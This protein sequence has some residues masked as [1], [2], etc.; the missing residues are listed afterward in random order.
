MYVGLYCTWDFPW[1]SPVLISGLIGD[2][3]N[4]NNF[5]LFLIYSPL[6]LEDGDELLQE[7]EFRV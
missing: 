7:G 6:P 3:N 5:I 2:Y 1:D 4:T